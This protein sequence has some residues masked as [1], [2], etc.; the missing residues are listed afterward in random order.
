MTTLWNRRTIVR[1]LFAALSVLLAAGCSSSP[2]P[3]RVA[4]SSP[5]PK[6]VS[7]DGHPEGRSVDIAF[8]VEAPPTWSA[9]GFVVVHE[10]DDPWLAISVWTVGKV[11]RNPCHPRGDLYDPGPTVDD[12]VRALETQSM[13]HATAPTDVTIGGYSGKYLEWSVPARMAVTGDSSFTGCDVE[14]GGRREFTSWHSNSGDPRWQQM[15][16]QV[17]RLWVLNV[18]GQRLLIDATNSPDATQSQ[19]DEERRIVQ[20]LRFVPAA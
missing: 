4:T 1:W 5:R 2:S 12:L 13:R 16:G 20:S 17:D 10:P 11:A 7:L 18:D 9:N 6:L 15:A 19:L 14:P 3:K 8:W